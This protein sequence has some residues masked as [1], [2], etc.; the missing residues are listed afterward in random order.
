[1]SSKYAHLSE[2]VSVIQ[3]CM[4]AHNTPFFIPQLTAL[5]YR[6]LDLR[7]RAQYRQFSGDVI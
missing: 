7:Y 4:L 6:V 3:N 1:M 2:C 5:I